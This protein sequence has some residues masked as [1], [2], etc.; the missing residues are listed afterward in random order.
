MSDKKTEKPK[1]KPAKQ[2]VITE[3]AN[4]TK[5]YDFSQGGYVNNVV[6]KKGEVA[7]FKF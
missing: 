3:K 1:D 2:P 5:T 4:A 6:V 7:N